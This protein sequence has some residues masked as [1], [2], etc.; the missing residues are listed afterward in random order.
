MSTWNFVFYGNQLCFKFTGSFA[1]EPTQSLFIKLK[2]KMVF[3]FSFVWFC[4]L[5]VQET[6]GNFT[7]ASS[8]VNFQTLL[9]LAIRA[10]KQA[11]SDRP[12][13]M[14]KSQI[15]HKNTH[16]KSTGAPSDHD[17]MST[18]NHVSLV[19]HHWIRENDFFFA[20][21]YMLK[22]VMLHIKCSS[23]VFHANMVFSTVV[24]EGSSRHAC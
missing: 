22:G 23:V 7:S 12:M 2:V 11:F 18:W 19:D 21:F 1:H 5:Q 20:W 4:R 9:E 16:W 3:L 14:E 10:L 17:F 13:D 15:T 6:L 24:I 8:H